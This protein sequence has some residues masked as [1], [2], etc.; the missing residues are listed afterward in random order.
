MLPLCSKLAEQEE[1]ILVEGLAISLLPT[2]KWIPLRNQ[3]KE[4]L[5][6]DQLE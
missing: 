6:S 3:N 4:L 5:E 2:K 1:W